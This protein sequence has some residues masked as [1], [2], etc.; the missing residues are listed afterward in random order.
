MELYRDKNVKA[1]I[2]LAGGD[3]ACEMLE[4]LDFDEILKLPPKWIQGYSDCTNLTLVFN[5]LCDIASIY[6]PTF[7]SFGM[8]NLH[9][10]LNNSLRLM[11]KEEFIQYSYEKCESLNYEENIKANLFIIIINVYMDYL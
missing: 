2:F 3:F 5:V 1:I 6:G 7:K 8:K 11:R 9:L 10:S 4:Y